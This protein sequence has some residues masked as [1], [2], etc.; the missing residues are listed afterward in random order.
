MYSEVIVCRRKRD[1]HTGDVRP[2][3]LISNNRCHVRLLIDLAT[4][5][6]FGDQIAKFLN[7]RYVF[8]FCKNNLWVLFCATFYFQHQGQAT[9][10]YSSIAFSMMVLIKQLTVYTSN[11]VNSVLNKTQT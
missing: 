1:E 10:S 9:L 3:G 2:V 5:E 8:G 4:V 6:L 7:V 11:H